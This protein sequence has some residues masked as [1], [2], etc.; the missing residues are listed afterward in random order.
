MR[1]NN[2]IETKVF[3]SNIRIQILAHLLTHSMSYNE[4]K[5][6][7]ICTDGNITTHTN[8]LKDAGFIS[9]TKEFENNRPL[10]TYHITEEGKQA[11]KDYIIRI[12]T[13]WKDA[14]NET[15]DELH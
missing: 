11:F 4:V 15:I 2:S 13:L 10:T 6:L 1:T 7:G 14:T 9:I 3:E 8:K 5:K 12:Y